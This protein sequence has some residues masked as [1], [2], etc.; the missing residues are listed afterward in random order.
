MICRTPI[1]SFRSISAPAGTASNYSTPAA[2]C[3]DAAH[4]HEPALQASSDAHCWCRI[5]FLRAFCLFSSPRS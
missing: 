5:P 2:L 4:L 1:S 3:F